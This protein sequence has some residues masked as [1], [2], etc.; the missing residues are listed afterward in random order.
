MQRLYLP[1]SP[2]SADF[3]SL[4]RDRRSCKF[5]EAPVQ[6]VPTLWEELGH[7][8]LDLL[9]MDIEGGEYAVIR[10]VV[11]SGVRPSQLWV[12]FH[13][14]FPLIPFARTREAIRR[15]LA[16]GYDIAHIRP[17]G[18]EFLFLMGSGSWNQI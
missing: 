8:R 4:P 9:K 12:E 16:V 15:L 2:R 13:H 5:I 7:S 18:L 10:D 6:R 3:T 1:R 14:N 17:R 11:E